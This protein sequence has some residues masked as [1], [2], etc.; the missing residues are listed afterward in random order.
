MKK[1][2]FT[3][4]ELLIVIAL[5]LLL[6]ALSVGV[7]VTVVYQ[8]QI[9]RTEGIIR[10]LDVALQ[11]YRIE[12]A[13]YP[14]GDGSARALEPYLCT[15]RK[16]YLDGRTVARKPLLDNAE[17]VDAWGHE[18]RYENPGARNASGVDVW[19]PGRDG[20]DGSADDV[21]NWE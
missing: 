14:P 17:F 4:V 20:L 12:H 1:R 21:A 13:A 7:I 18:I 10:R 5:V 16:S 8:A 15:P 3:L 19:S 11:N 6:S 9:T 2:G